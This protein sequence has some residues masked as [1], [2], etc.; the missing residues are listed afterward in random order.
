MPPGFGAAL[1]LGAA[2]GRT[3][4]SAFLLALDAALAAPVTQEAIERVLASPLTERERR[5]TAARG[6]RR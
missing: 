6:S 1:R 3:A 5:G 2:A 4:E